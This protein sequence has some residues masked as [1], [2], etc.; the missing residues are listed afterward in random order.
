MNASDRGR[1]NAPE[2]G[3]PI[4]GF[5]RFLARDR[6]WLLRLWWLLAPLALATALTYLRV[7]A[8]F[9]SSGLP[10]IFYFPAIIATTLIAGLDFGIAA[11]AGSLLLV[12]FLFAPPPLT[13]QL[14]TRD[15]TA[16]LVLWA[17]VSAILACL[18][19]LLRTA[20]RQ[21][22]YNEMRYRNLVELTS[23]I[24]WVTDRD[25]RAFVPNDAF[26]RITGMK[27]PDYGGRKWLN[28]IHEDDRLALM[29][30][31][32][33]ADEYHEVEFRLMDAA[34]GDWRWFRS[35]AVAIK[36]PQGDIVEWITA[37][38]DVHEP[39]LARERNAILLGEARHRLKNLIAIIAALATSS[40]PPRPETNSQS[41]AFLQRFLGRLHALGAAADLAL[42]G[43]NRVMDLGE[44]IE[45]TLAAFSEGN[46]R[47]EIS[48]PR[49]VLGQEAGGSIALAVHELATNAVK[50]GSLSVPEGTVSLTWSVTP[51]GENERVD[52]VWKE[53]GG[54]S[55]RPP[56]KEGYG[57]R[58]IRAAVSRGRE[59]RADIAYAPEGL[60]CELSFLQPANRDATAHG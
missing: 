45:A 16:T 53:A 32:A 40:R 3:F 12:W 2:A 25:G 17:V 57:G 24:V 46:S 52:I 15:Q 35:R 55:V 18:S 51:L 4:A 29:P 50:Y 37:M 48:G 10:L 59:G 14:L 28:G 58:V 43:D 5:V 22:F 47:I 54:P 56:E 26:A 13:W 8:G 34:T 9:G 19:F 27:W 33:R 31:G 42:A 38:R 36:S 23:D 21:L 6:H 44:A 41:E 49:A 20:L 30:S 60:S 1:S 11:I 39:R 7:F